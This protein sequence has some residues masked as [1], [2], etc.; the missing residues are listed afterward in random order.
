MEYKEDLFTAS[1]ACA[2][3]GVTSFLEMP[4]TSHLTSDQ[5]ALT[6]KLALAS[7]KCLVNYS[8]FIG[9]TVD[10]VDELNAANP[11][12]GI[13]IF[14]GSMHGPLLV[15]QDEALERIFSNG[16]RLIAVYAEDQARI[17][18]HRKELGPTVM[19]V[20]DAHQYQSQSNTSLTPHFPG[21]SSPFHHR[22]RNP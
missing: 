19:R 2:R 1:S 7:T 10:N 4:N 17:R 9:A 3:G 6:A 11:T 13:K 5:T 22:R 16:T 18:Q 12:P 14:M 8:F 21:L 20:V 15:N